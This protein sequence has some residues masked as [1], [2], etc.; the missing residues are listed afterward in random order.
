MV[1]HNLAWPDRCWSATSK[2][3]R[4]RRRGVVLDLLTG[5]WLCFEHA[6]WL[7][8][9]RRHVLA[10]QAAA[11]FGLDEPTTEPAVAAAEDLLRR[12]W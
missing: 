5:C 3:G 4:C 11:E 10:D 6:V 8:R 9:L 7:D 2:R 12:R 1:I